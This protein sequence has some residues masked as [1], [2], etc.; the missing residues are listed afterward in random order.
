[1]STAAGVRQHSA[2]DLQAYGRRYGIDY[3]V[4]ALASREEEPVVRGE[5]RELSLG[6]GMELVASDVEVLHRY[7][8][9]SHAP[10]PLSI[11]VMLEGCAD[12]SLEGRTLTLTPGMA[13]SLRL[14]ARHG[15]RATQPA[16]Q[17]LRALTLSLSETRLAELGPAQPGHDGSRMHAWRPPISLLQGLEQALTTPLPA[18]AQRL[19]FEGLGLQLVAFG[20]PQDTLDD[21]N[22]SRLPPREQRRLERVRAALED[23]PAAE[24]SLS[25]LAELAAMSPASLR[26][27]FRAAFGVSVFDYLRDCRLGLAHDYLSRGFSVQQAA[28]FCGYRHAS[29]FATAFRRRYGVA[30]S[31]L[32]K[33]S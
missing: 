15:L 18:P 19:L 26:R 30:P 23:D 5:V 7:D 31:S 2:R 21:A 6:Q 13:L 1:M 9:H 14:D 8:S 3:R 17:R 22:A 33:T 10:S 32:T 29:N 20:L 27:K 24:H 4:P 28:H 25:A 12:V 11:V 16:G